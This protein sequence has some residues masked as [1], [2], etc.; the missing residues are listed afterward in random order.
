MAKQKSMLIN[1]SCGCDKFKI[2]DE[3]IVCAECDKEIKDEKVCF[4]QPTNKKLPVNI[5][6]WGV[7]LAATGAG[8]LIGIAIGTAAVAAGYCI[9]VSISPF[10]FPI[11]I[12]SLGYVAGEDGSLLGDLVSDKIYSSG[13]YGEQLAKKFDSVFE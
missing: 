12:K 5:G 9:E 4:L 3:K 11:A 13:T 8:V 2:V 10:A 7:E 1:C 6:K